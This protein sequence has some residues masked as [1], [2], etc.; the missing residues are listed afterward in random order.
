MT[1][2]ENELLSVTRFVIREATDPES[3][4]VVAKLAVPANVLVDDTPDTL[5]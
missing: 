2:V 5:L 3:A 4:Y 1:L